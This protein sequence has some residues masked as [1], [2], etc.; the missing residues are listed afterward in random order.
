V[1]NI[2]SKKGSQCFLSIVVS[3]I[4]FYFVLKSTTTLIIETEKS[5]SNLQD[6]VTV[7]SNGIGKEST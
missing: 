5:D 1:Y 7:Y 2:P 6:F 3:L 4:F